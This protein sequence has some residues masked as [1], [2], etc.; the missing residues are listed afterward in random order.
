MSDQSSSAF[1]INSWL[2][3]ELYQNYLHDRR[4]VDES[5]KTVFEE[6]GTAAGGNG[7]HSAPAAV[8]PPP[9][10]QTP[11][12]AATPVSG[13]ELVPL[14]G[15]ALKIAENMSA[16][17]TLP[18][19]TTM[20]VIA[21]RQME[22]SR[23]ILNQHR[24]KLGQSKISFT[25]LIGWALIEALQTNPALNNAFVETDGQSY[26]AVRGTV[27]LGIAVDVAGKDG[28]RSLKVPN[29]KNAG[30]LGFAAFLEAFD[31]VVGRARD[32]KLTLADFEG[33]TISL[34]NPGTVGTFGSIPRLMPGQGAIIATG[35]IDYPPEFRA[36]DESAR[37]ALGVGK[38]MMMTSTYDHRVIQGA[39]SGL[40]LARMQ[41][42]LEGGDG[43]YDRIFE[44]LGVSTQA[45]AP[46]PAEPAPRRA[47]EVVSDPGYA[48]KQAG[49]IQLI[50]AFRV[51]GHLIA[52]LDPLGFAPRKPHSELDPESY[53]LTE[54][55]LDTEFLTGNLQVSHHKDRCAT[56]A[57]ILAT[58]RTTY[59]GTMTCEYMH[60]Q[61]PEEKQ[62]LQK[63]MEPLS[64]QW[65]LD[66]AVRLRALD[67]VIEAE[68]FEHFLHTRFIG[69]KRFSLEGGESA[70]VVLDEIL[71]R[72]ASANVKEI[73]IGMAHRGRLS[74]LANIVGKSMVQVF[75][76]FEGIDP[77][78]MQ[79]SGDVKYHLG[80]TGVR[81][82]SEGKEITLS[83]A[84]NPSHLEAVD[85]VV[86]GIV[87]R[88]QYL[89]G[90][91]GQARVLPLLIHGDAAFAGQGVVWETLNLSQLE[92]YT[93]GGTV[94]L[95]INNQ[96]GFTTNPIEATSAQYATDIARAVQA[97]IFH[98]NGDDPD[99]CVR[100]TQLAYDFRQEFKKD[101]VIDMVCYRRHGH[102]EA[103]DPSYTQPLLYKKIKTHPSVAVLYAERLVN[104]GLIGAA[105][106]QNA[107]KAVTSRLNAIYDASKKNTEAYQVDD[108]SAVDL[109]HVE[110]PEEISTAITPE[111]AEHVIKGITTFPPGFHVHPKLESFLEKRRQVLHGGPMDWAAGEAIAFGSLVM[112]STPVRLSGQDSARGTFSQRHLE[113]YDYETGKAFI[114]MQHL[115]PGQA[116]FEVWDSSLSE[117]A[118]MGFEFGFSVAGPL[119]L[120]LWEAQFG[121][122]VNGAQ[123]M[124]DQFVA[125]AETKWAQPSGLVLLLPHGQEGQGPEHSS[126][127]IERFLQLCGED[128]MQVANCSTPAQYFHILRRQMYGGPQRRGIRKPLVIFTPK[129]MLRNPRAVSHLHDITS[130]AFEEVL[131]DTALDNARVRRVL[132]TSGQVYFDLLAAREQKKI[133]DV[134][135]VRL[136]Q[137]YPF[138]DA[139]MRAALA[140]YPAT[141]GV[142]WVQEEPRNMGA[143]RFV[144][145]WLRPILDETKRAVE[146]V[147]RLESSSPGPGSLKRHQQE[148][149]EL[150]EAAFADEPAAPRRRGARRKK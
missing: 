44:A 72:A 43:F 141:A 145:E 39:E 3:D 124:I 95:V 51:R 111:L 42:L 59:C 142:R 110:R 25:H 113:Y 97:P 81:K 133:T 105:G 114:P 148:Q 58:L 107:R 104:E 102:N 119:T 143:W 96:I 34:T 28:S 56:L 134:A 78:S 69:H 137:Y 116:R 64:N 1:G 121:D 106:V 62:W 91:S 66:Q 54:A 136:E 8:A 11:N 57:E 55:D 60:I 115:S 20:R 17:L 92:G 47:A 7:N 129:R 109:D 13:E 85:P 40:F 147:G 52:N 71:E 122:F 33:T 86:E 139:K 65:P 68:E 18:T 31:S 94:H 29:I 118:V 100:A 149:A 50:H 76:E 23:N 140:L 22:I 138:P 21:V 127:R 83:V 27:N 93:T 123:I 24:A 61:V 26:R 101:V 37:A 77:E 67:R 98:V 32:N 9:V 38:V 30:A 128:N 80:A 146:Y 90:D 135:I 41:R 19:A 49:V 36:L 99:A 120:V 63:R 126:A 4:T 73:V 15:V 82:N 112:E 131:A 70:I 89:L 12:P 117:F 14:R 130:G 75:S 150:I 144:R 108:L 103:D 88:K 74:V 53:G 87:R 132:V 48:A 46:A 6:D 125:T 2:E 16:S 45:A 35:A 10:V 84:F 79:G 5:W